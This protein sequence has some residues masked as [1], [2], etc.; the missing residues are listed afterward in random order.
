MTDW[1]RRNGVDVSYCQVDRLMRQERLHG[2]RRGR[3]KATT[4]RVDTHTPATDLVD[5]KFTAPIPDQLWIADM[6]YESTWAGW[7]Y[8]PPLSSRCSPN[9]SSAGRS[10]RR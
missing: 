3:I 1:L 2:L 4:R 6:T 10:R 8:T 5:R 9:A 7:C